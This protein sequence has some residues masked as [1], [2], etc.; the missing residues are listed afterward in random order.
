MT[1]NVPFGRFGCHKYL[2]TG[3]RLYI[4]RLMLHAY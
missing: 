3:I 4:L 1:E 2:G